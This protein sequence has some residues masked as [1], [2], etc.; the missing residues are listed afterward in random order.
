[1]VAG[2]VVTVSSQIAR[3]MRERNSAR[4]T[5]HM[6]V[7]RRC[8]GLASRRLFKFGRMCN[9]VPFRVLHCAA[10]PRERG[11]RRSAELTAGSAKAQAHMSATSSRAVIGAWREEQK[12]LIITRSVQCWKWLTWYNCWP[13]NLR[14]ARSTAV[15]W[16]VLILASTAAHPPRFG[17]GLEWAQKASRTTSGKAPFIFLVFL[18]TRRRRSRP[19]L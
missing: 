19:C 15:Q 12:D 16:R 7:A 6:A 2:D 13:L 14:H 1:M 18:L 9:H 5:I 11:K 8:I 10:R 3:C 17:A 4:S